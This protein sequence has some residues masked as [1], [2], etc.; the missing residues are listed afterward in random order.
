MAATKTEAPV[1][2]QLDQL[3]RVRTRLT[4][5]SETPLICHRWSEKARKEMLDSQMRKAKKP[6]EAKNPE[7]DF[8]DSLYPHPDGGYGFPA[9]AFKASA[10]RA[11]KYISGF[12]MIFLKCAIHINTELVKI[13]GDP[14]PREDMVRV[15]GKADIRFRGQFNDWRT[16]IEIEHFVQMIST[17]Q[18]LALFNLAG[19]CVGVGEWRPE[20]GG[21]YGRFRVATAGEVSA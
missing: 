20:K 19:S 16:D 1:A 12:D 21:I 2:V 15:Q 7:H 9:V 5:F 13:E 17:E 18:V 10:V 6:K 14:R 11:G 4:L 3:D 8:L